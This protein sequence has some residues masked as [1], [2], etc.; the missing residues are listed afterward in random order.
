MPRSNSF[1]D[2]IVEDVLGHISGITS[3][4]MFSGHGIYLDGVIV[5]LI[6]DGEFYLKADKT[7]KG[8]GKL[9]EYER[10]PPSHKPARQ[11]AGGATDGRGGKIVSL[12][13]ATVPIEI[14]EDR[15]KIEE[16]IY[17]SFEISKKA[18]K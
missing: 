15:E 14:L 9:F 5:G 4:A 17:K 7:T 2:Y 10:N 18:K 3:R 12:P 13:Y 6:I 1:K 11:L 16:L 8:L